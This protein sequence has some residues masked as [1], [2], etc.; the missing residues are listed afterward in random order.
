MNTNTR[1]AHRIRIIE[2]LYQIDLGVLE[3]PTLTDVPFVNETLQ[4]ILEHQ[5]SIDAAISGALVNYTIKRL[6]YVDRAIIRLAVFEMMFTQTP[7]EIILDEALEL[8][9]QYTDLGD[10]KSVAFNNKLLD[11]ILKTLKEGPSGN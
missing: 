6:S 7:S 1:H 11:T 3:A 4:G 2:T 8:T 9:H 5:A 10:S